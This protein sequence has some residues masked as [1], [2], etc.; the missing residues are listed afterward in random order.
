MPLE[1]IWRT[2]IAAGRNS[3]AKYHP[4]CFVLLLYRRESTVFREKKNRGKKAKG[5][6]QPTFQSRWRY[7]SRRTLKIFVR[8]PNH[9]KSVRREGQAPTAHAEHV[10]HLSREKR[11]DEGAT[12][13]ETRAVPCTPLC[14][15]T[16]MVCPAISTKFILYPILPCA[17]SYY[18]QSV[19]LF[20]QYGMGLPKP[21]SILV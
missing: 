4:G 7:S 6:H 18:V 10:Q 12:P 13:R 14:P 1:G 20:D 8:G 9:P 5:V 17:V 3:L 19:P 16:G 11:F 21:P 2:E 15:A